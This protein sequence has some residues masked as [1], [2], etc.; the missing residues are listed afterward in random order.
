V[1]LTEWQPYRHPNLA[2]LR[3]LMAT[4]VVF[5]GRNLWDPQ[6]MAELGFE[7]ESIGRPKA[8]VGAEV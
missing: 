6:K 2:R 4:P 8:G 7:Y 5:D 1:V 3:D